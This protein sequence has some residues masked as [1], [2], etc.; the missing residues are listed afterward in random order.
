MLSSVQKPMAAPVEQAAVDDLVKPVDKEKE[1]LEIQKKKEADD[2]LKE[3]ER[4]LQQE[5]L[6]KKLAEEAAAKAAAAKKKAQEEEAAK[7]KE[8]QR[9]IQEEKEKKERAVINKFKALAI[10]VC[11]KYNE[12]VKQTLIT[13]VA[14]KRPLIGIK[15]QRSITSLTQGMSEVNEEEYLDL[16][17]QNIPEV[18]LQKKISEIFHEAQ[19]K[20]KLS[21]ISTRVHS[22]NVEQL[23]KKIFDEQGQEGVFRVKLFYHKVNFETISSASDNLQAILDLMS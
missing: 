9:K 22:Y 2:R 4:Q 21:Q 12:L 19:L 23:A 11:S 3:K 6:E 13:F 5:Q 20:T 14:E 10:K 1:L 16:V 15:R 8:R 18:T 17:L 7:E